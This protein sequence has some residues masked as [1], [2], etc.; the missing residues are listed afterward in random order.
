MIGAM[1]D[2]L[3]QRP[4]THITGYQ[5]VVA[6]QN[7]LPRHWIFRECPPDYGIDCE[8]EIVSPNDGAVTGAVLKGQVK[9]SSPGVSYKRHGVSVASNTVRYWLALPVPV[10]LIWV[11]GDQPI[12]RWLD[13][14]HYLSANDTLD[15]V[16]SSGQQS[17]TF[18]FKGAQTLP[19]DAWLLKELALQHQASVVEMRVSQDEQVGGQFIGYV[20]MVE[21]FDADHDRWIQWLRENGS[22]DQLVHDLPFAFWVKHQAET[23]PGFLDRVRNMVQENKG[24]GD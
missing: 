21:L 8:V 3:P 23:D 12:V 9:G 14:R 17:Y 11:A 20:V 5:A 1:A 22:K 16:Y 24:R 13:V 19:E 4:L 15:S 2:R 6:L 18:N 10:I 7:V